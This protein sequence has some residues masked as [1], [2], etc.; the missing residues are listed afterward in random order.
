[1]SLHSLFSRFCHFPMIQGRF[2]Y[3]HM[4]RTCGPLPSIQ[5]HL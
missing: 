4:L 3:S 2:S 1:M 5:A